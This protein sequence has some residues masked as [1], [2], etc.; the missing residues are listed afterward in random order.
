MRAG[1]DHRQRGR[2]TGEEA[3]R[4]APFALVL[5]LLAPPA[6]AAEPLGRLFYTPDQRS[7][8]DTARSKRARTA[9]ATEKE[10]PP[11]PP[12]PEVVTYG[13]MVRRSDGKTTV[14]LNNH[15]VGEKEAAS[16][17]VGK[18]RPDGSVTLQSPQTGKNVELR[19][20]Q[21]AELLSGRV[22]EV[23]RQAPARK[24]ELTPAE[25]AAKPEG[26]A[27]TEAE[28]RKEERERQE[29]MDDALRALR[30]A[31]QARSAETAAPTPPAFPPLREV[32]T[33]PLRPPA[34]AQLPAGK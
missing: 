26:A 9:L 3:V 5:T 12:S 4:L 6:V 23:Y 8:L 13:G 21:R 2:D 28:R 31:A 33:P 30:D 22:E 19:V 7:S 18:V 29:N 10:E 25:P 24:P 14:W 20:G 27:A 15:A 1:V 16:R 17:L 32:G 11:A 34:P